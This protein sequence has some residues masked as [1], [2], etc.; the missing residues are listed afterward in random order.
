MKFLTRLEVSPLSDGYRWV[1]TAPLVCQLPSGELVTVPAGFVTD[2]ASIPRLFW[3]FI[4][5]T[6]RH[7]MAAVLHD[8]LYWEQ[9]VSRATADRYFLLGMDVCRTLLTIRWVMYLSV[10]AWGWWAWSTNARHKAAGET[11]ILLELPDPAEV[12]PPRGLDWLLSRVVGRAAVVVLFLLS[13]LLIFAPGCAAKREPAP[14]EPMNGEAPHVRVRCDFR[15]MAWARWIRC[16]GFLHGQLPSHWLCLQP[17]WTFGDGSS[18]ITPR[19]EV[20]CTEETPGRLFE[21]DHKYV[22]AGS[23]SIRLQLRDARGKRVADGFT[24]VEIMGVR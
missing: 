2:F 11:R 14:R 6:G 9:T 10:R 17:T 12:L 15:A 20:T 13:A 19:Q 3:M 23:F 21:A 16:K 7:G 24:V 18:P 8:Y 5:R 1:L 4:E 22:D